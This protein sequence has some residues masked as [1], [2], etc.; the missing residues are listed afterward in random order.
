MDSSSSSCQ[1]NQLVMFVSRESKKNKAVENVVFVPTDKNSARSN[2]IF[3]KLSE[4]YA[5]V[6]QKLLKNDLISLSKIRPLFEPYPNWYEVQFFFNTIEFPI[7]TL[8]D[9]CILSMLSKTTSI[10]V[11][12]NL[13][14]ERK[15]LIIL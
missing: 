15:I 5:N 4:S 13:M 1:D 11:P 6:L 2:R 12:F 14:V 9:A 8:N 7:M 3:T 10:A